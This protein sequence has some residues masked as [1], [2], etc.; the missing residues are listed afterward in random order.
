LS[1]ADSTKWDQLYPHGIEAQTAGKDQEAAGWLHAAAQIDDAVAELRF[2][3][4]GCALT[5]GETAGAQG[6]FMAA[7]DL[8]T[9]RFRCDSRL[10]DLIRQTVS[11][12]ESQQV[13]LADAERVFA[14][15]SPGGSPG[16]NFFY[17]HVHLTFGGNYLLARTLVPQIE[18]LLPEK[19][20]TRVAANQSWPSEADCA[21]RLA[22]SD[23]DE[24]AA[25]SDI[26]VRFSD[27]PF[28]SQLNHAAQMQNLKASLEKLAPATQPAGIVAA[29]KIYETAVTAAPDDPLLREPLAALEQSSGDL[30]DAVTNAQCAVDL[31]PSSS[32]AWSQLGL[33]L[34]QQQK[35]AEATVA[36]RRAFE[37]DSEDVWALQN[38][39]QSLLKLGRRDEAIR[40]YR[41]ALAIKP[42]FGLAWLG[43]GQ[44]L[45][46]Q[47]RRTEAEDCYRKGLAN[48]IHRA[49]ELTTLARF[50]ESRGWFEAAATNYD[51]AIRMN[52]TDATL[53]LNAGQSY[54]AAGRPAEAMQHYA[55]AVQLSPES[56]QAHFLYGLELGKIGKAAEAAEQFR[57]AVRIMPDF[58]EARLNLGIALVNER[59]Y[60]EALA[61][62]ETVLERNPTNAVALRYVRMVRE[63]LSATPPH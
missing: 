55:E 14:E 11:S 44:V 24:Q 53:Y 27:P 39:A 15:Q 57:D 37:L 16:A 8:D 10:N 51:D 1:E 26:F 58:A 4:A 61:Q 25:L 59:I 46:G 34:A 2:R 49:S 60:S 45:E 7:R 5:L 20:A 30:A 31:L 36:F 40:E 32:E 50:C 23:R 43:L 6:Y 18:K 28:T 17:D 38:L 54:A 21:R 42:R 22:W 33:I 13:L 41:R 62:F 3:Q 48:R 56:M 35:F 47:G 29:R 12:R 63:K 19:I 52:P 9:L